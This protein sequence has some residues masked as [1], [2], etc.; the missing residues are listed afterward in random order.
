MESS[1]CRFVSKE[2]VVYSLADLVIS[3]CLSVPGTRYYRISKCVKS[4]DVVNA[5]LVTM[6]SGTQ[7]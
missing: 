5:I 6:G 3:Q 2:T 1:K 4:V 7:S